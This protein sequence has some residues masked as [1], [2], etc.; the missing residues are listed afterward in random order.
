MQMK[1]SKSHLSWPGKCANIIAYPN[2]CGQHCRRQLPPL[3]KLSLQV[4]PPVKPAL[5]EG[6]G[7]AARKGRSFAADDMVRNGIHRGNYDA[8]VPS[9]WVTVICPR[10]IAFLCAGSLPLKEKASKDEMTFKH[11]YAAALFALH[12]CEGHYVRVTF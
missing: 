10:T 1:R 6:G 9:K 12:C 4:H 5:K 11:T 8:R 2:Q 3:T 7:E